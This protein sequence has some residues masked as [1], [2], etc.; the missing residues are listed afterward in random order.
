MCTRQKSNVHWNKSS[1]AQTAQNTSGSADSQSSSAI[2]TLNV[3]LVEQK[4]RIQDTFL[5]LYFLRMADSKC[6]SKQNKGKQRKNNPSSLR[7][8]E[9]LTKTSKVIII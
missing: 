1:S 9:L 8:S 3:G 4:E 2:L 6:A 5:R 7:S